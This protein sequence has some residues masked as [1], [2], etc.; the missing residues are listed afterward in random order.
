MTRTTILLAIGLLAMAALAAC[1]PAVVEAR[2]PV[3]LVVDGPRERSLGG[4][5]D[6]T[7]A[8]LL[9]AGFSG[10]YGPEIMTSIAEY[11]DLS[12]A[13]A[14]TT[15][16]DLGRI[17]RADAGLYVAVERLDRDVVLDAGG[18]RRTVH[19]RLQL[20]FTVVDPAT[21]ALLWSV[22]DAP[23][24]ALRIERTNLPLP[25]LSADPGVVAMRDAALRDRVA[26]IVARLADLPRDLGRDDAGR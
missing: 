17:A 14:L 4:L 16:A 1:A 11:R 25:E 3:V 18:Q 9:R 15:T 13:Q 24:T 21:G 12:A 19:V 23:R 26:D 7:R 5:A 20:R 8:A 22:L 10:S 2:R 6:A